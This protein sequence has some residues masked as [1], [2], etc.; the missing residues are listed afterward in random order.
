[1]SQEVKLVQAALK[2]PQDFEPIIELYEPKLNRFLSHLGVGVEEDREDLLQEIFWKVY[3]NLNSFDQDMSLN[4]WI[5]RIARNTAYD[6]F[7]KIKSRGYKI[8]F[9]EEEA[10][11]FWENLVDESLHFTEEIDQ[12]KRQALVKEILEQVPD[13]Y[14]EVLILLFLEDRSYQEIADILR[15]NENTIA[16]LISRGK[17]KFKQLFRSQ[18]N[19]ILSS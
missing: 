10:V 16:T 5:Y 9:S 6:H 7:R 11:F 4:A 13:K 3:Q 8:E 18:H 15:K 19:Q 1:M 17:Q 14:R 12:K 2:N